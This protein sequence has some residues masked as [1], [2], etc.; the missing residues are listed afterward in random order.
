MGRPTP[1]SCTLSAGVVSGLRRSIPSPVGT[2]IVGAIQTDALV[3]KQNSGGPLL[4]AGC[5]MI[6]FTTS[7]FVKN[8]VERSS[9]V[10][11][12]VPVDMLM[13][14]VPRLILTGSSAGRGL[15]SRVAA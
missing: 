14:S 11:F 10:N 8:D 5:R 4:D 12:A 2:R 6:G 3:S 1:Q 7:S 9:G 15:F 13:Q